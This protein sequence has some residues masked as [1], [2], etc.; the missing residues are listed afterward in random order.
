MDFLE[1]S[2]RRDN[3]TSVQLVLLDVTPELLDGLRAGH[4]LPAADRRQVS[5]QVHR[6]EETNA[7]LLHS[8]RGLLSARLPV[9][10]DLHPLDLQRALRRRLLRLRQSRRRRNRGLR[11]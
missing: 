8:D 5:A 3:T 4:L 6:S 2:I 7:L 1:G 9:L 10:L 11:G